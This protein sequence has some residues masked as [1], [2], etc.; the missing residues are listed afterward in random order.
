[1]NTHQYWPGIILAI[2]SFFLLLPLMLWLPEQFGHAP[3]VISAAQ[4]EGYNNRIAHLTSL[5]WILFTLTGVWVLSRKTEPSPIAPPRSVNRPG[6]AVSCLLPMITILAVVFLYF[7]PALAPKGSYFEESIHLTAIHRMLGGDVPYLDFEFLYGPLMLYPAYWWTQLTSFSLTSFYTY[8]MM[9]ELLVMLALLIPIQTYISSFWARVGTFLLLSSLYFNTMLGPNQNGLRKLMGVLILISVAQ[10]PLHFGLSVLHGVAV[11]LLLSYSQEF[12]AATAIGILAIYASLFIKLRDKRAILALL[13]TGAVSCI[14][15]LGCLWLLLGPAMMDYFSVIRYLT[16]QFDSGEAAF[17][18]Y[19]TASSLA[20]FALILIA[21]WLV[22]TALSRKWTEMPGPGDLLAIGA[23]AYA[24]LLLKS[25]LSRADQWHLVPCALPIAFSLILPL[26]TSVMPIT[27]RVRV[28][29]IMLTLIL[30]LTYSFGQF[31]IV[32]Y[33][34]REGLL[35]NYKAML[36]DQ[37]TQTAQHIDSET[38]NILNERR[39][40]SEDIVELATFLAEPPQ[41]GARVFAYDRLWPLPMKVG[42][43]KFG[44]LTDNFI[45]GDDR[46]N[47]LRQALSENPDVLVVIEREAYDWL[48]STPED[49]SAT[50]EPDWISSGQF[51]RLR[52]ILSS[53]HVPAVPTEVAQIQTRWRR[54]VGNYLAD[55]YTP[56]FSNGSYVVLGHQNKPA[57]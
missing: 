53:A 25:G 55:T 38:P 42:V 3:G 57:E 52:E 41:R 11:G 9:L 40:P 1:M 36:S 50:P 5:L 19:W 14:V 6:L 48:R 15:W 54:L 22:G 34:F 44:Y 16:A 2:L 35:A 12:G 28:L 46:G 4:A 45:Y 20:V 56:I 21:I 7:P 18:F 24:A 32:R 8:V 39:N 37:A 29:G 17:R 30:A 51:G 33:V 43:S 27:R 23:L 47:L 13:L 26:R 49:T 31:T 10:R